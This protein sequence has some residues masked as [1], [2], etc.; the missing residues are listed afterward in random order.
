MISDACLRKDIQNR[1]AEKDLLQDLYIAHILVKQQI[2]VKICISVQYMRIFCG[3]KGTVPFGS[4]L[5]YDLQDIIFP[6]IRADF[7]QLLRNALE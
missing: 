6:G 7:V 2:S 1:L 5:P 3:T 4:L